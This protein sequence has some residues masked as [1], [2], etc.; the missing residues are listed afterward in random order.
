MFIIAHTQAG[1]NVA[2]QIADRLEGVSLAS[3][4]EAVKSPESLGDFDSIGLV[5]EQEGKAI[6]AVVIS[7][8]K[9]VLGSYD[10]K[11]LEYMFSLCLC[12]N[13]SYHSLKIV[14]K[15][16]SKVGC[17]PSLNLPVTSGTDIESVVSQ[18][19]GGDIVLPKGSLG[20]MFFMKAHK[21][22]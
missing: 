9:D 2:S 1:T 17:T 10:L 14:E 7:F 13:E 22:R 8:I 4:E 19:K 6:P 18:I 12:D 15:L 3:I 16:C 20:T 11:G 5:Y 21:I